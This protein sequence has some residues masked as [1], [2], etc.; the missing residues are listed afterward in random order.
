MRTYEWL[1]SLQL[2]YAKEIELRQGMARER[3]RKRKGRKYGWKE[4]KRDC[5]FRYMRCVKAE[6]SIA[7]REILIVCQFVSTDDRI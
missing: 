3:K 4:E 7:K 6:V 2:V 1:S 5:R